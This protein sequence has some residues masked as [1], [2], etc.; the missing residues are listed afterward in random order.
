MR[1]VDRV[2]ATRLHLWLYV[3]RAMTWLR[4]AAEQ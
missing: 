1:V 2:S 3:F 4:K